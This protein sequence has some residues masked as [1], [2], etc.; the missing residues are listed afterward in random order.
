MTPTERTSRSALINLRLPGCVLVAGLAL[1][2]AAVW[3][4]VREIGRTE[5]ARFDQLVERIEVAMEG[6][7]GAAVE[8]LTLGEKLVEADTGLTAAVWRNHVNSVWP[9]VNKGVVGLGY[10]ER[11]PRSEVAT[12]E[13]RIR[14]AGTADFTVERAGTHDSLYVV[15]Y[16]GPEAL[17]RGARG[18]DIASGTTR[19]TAA[20]AAMATGQLALSRRI[21][22]VYGA[23]T[24]PGF[25]LLLPHYAPGRPTGTVAERTAALKGWVYASLRSDLI[26]GDIPASLDD[27]ADIDVFEGR[28]TSTA[29]LLFD[30]YRNLPATA[31][32]RLIDGE[33]YKER[34]FSDVR[35][36]R[37]H[38]QEWTNP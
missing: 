24:V 28:T 2:A 32:E 31:A 18:L 1:T 20:E 8:A 6:R 37:L 34:R 36:L 38:G 9:F 12:L 11:W 21:R 13:G 29:T 7:F 15:T 4:N 35:I 27:Q 23:E 30:S 17:N 14:A 10:I 22:L 26:V 16:L 5:R 33:D 3:F 19:K 25:L